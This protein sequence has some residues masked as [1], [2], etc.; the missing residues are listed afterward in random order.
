MGIAPKSLN[1]VGLGIAL[2]IAVAGCGGG[3]SASSTADA[4]LAAAEQHSSGTQQRMRA[5]A[6][7]GAVDAEALLDWAEFKFPA[8][9][10]KGSSS[11]ALD[12]EGRHYTVR[13]YSHATDAR[14]LGV[15]DQNE[16]F[17]LGDFTGGILQGF[18]VV[19]DYAAQVKADAC[20]VNPGSCGSGG[21]SSAY[22]VYG[23][24]STTAGRETIHVVD[25]ATPTTVA[26]SAPNT[27]YSNILTTVA[28]TIDPA[29]RAYTR[30]GEPQLFF[31]RDRGLYRVALTKPGPPV[32]VRVSS[33]SDVC[34]LYLAAQLDSSGDV[35][36]LGVGT[37]GANGICTDA[38]DVQ[39][40]VLSNTAST[41]PAL[42][43]PPQVWAM[44]NG[45]I[46]DGTGRLQWVLVNDR[47]SAGGPRIAAYSPALAR[48]EITGGS[49]VNTGSVTSVGVPGAG[50]T[51]DQGIFL[52]AD[53]DLRQLTAAGAALS[54]G[55]SRYTFTSANSGLGMTDGPAQYFPDANKLVKVQGNGPA[56]V[57]ATLPAAQG[58]ING[59]SQTAGHI[60]VRQLRF[61]PIRG[62][63]TTAISKAD[64]SLRLLLNGDAPGPLP[65]P[66]GLS[67][68]TLY[69]STN[70]Q[71]K[72]GDLRRMQTDGSGDVSVSPSVYPMRGV[73]RTSGR[74]DYTQF[75]FGAPMSLLMCKPAAGAPDCRSGVLN[76]FDMAAQKLTSLGNFISN[77]AP[78]WSAVGLGWDGLDG[79]VV[80]ATGSATS[81]Q[82]GYERRDMWLANPGESNSLRRVTTTMP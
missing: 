73:L 38:D 21:T 4:A 68:E 29:S 12:H 18:G 53:N 78:A 23:T 16:V 63:S 71:G 2:A 51:L 11:F 40:L 64:G 82:P 6:E 35:A 33:R 74:A 81:A 69:Y 54:L 56:T 76:Q 3:S 13:A 80:T 44:S 34:G 60:V 55:P 32:A 31:V 57:F 39:A 66:L 49:G 79:L 7:S 77:A 59:L 19:A 26:L 5:L 46:Y 62:S 36:V 10:P 22:F 1:A 25:P 67:G 41:A 65:T 52:R 42:V 70:D 48:V 47:S 24:S 8:L 37:A 72:L 20:S 75:F 14:Y 58:D 45:A 43:L 9:F 17:G 27:L 30:R 50:P 61:V 15:T 28:L